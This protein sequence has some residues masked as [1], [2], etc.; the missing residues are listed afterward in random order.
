MDTIQILTNLLQNNN[1]ITLITGVVTL[2]SAIAAISGTPKDGT[3]LAK[4]YFL[5]DLL[6]LNIGKAKDKGISA[7]PN[8]FK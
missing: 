3:L 1:Y 6:A 2:A 5:I 4:V 8:Q 7:D